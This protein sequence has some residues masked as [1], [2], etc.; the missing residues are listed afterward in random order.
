MTATE[1]PLRCLG[2]AGAPPELSAD[3]AR[4]AALSEEARK[5]FWEALGPSLAEPVPPELERKL[6]VFCAE[7]RAEPADLARAIKAARSLLRGAARH[8]VDAAGFLSDLEILSTDNTVIAI[9][10]LGFERAVVA[11]RRDAARRAIAGHGNVL[12][13]V[14]WRI[15][16]VLDTKEARGLGVEIAVVTL[17][18]RDATGEKTVTLHA[19]PDMLEE[20]K[21]I[22]VVT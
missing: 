19:L 21:R 5:H 20:L 12:T 1:P 11:L 17:R 6:D 8:G 10:G 22:G 18:Y 14:D 16:R 4:I 15:D 3:L 13:A 2:G 7:H 9:L